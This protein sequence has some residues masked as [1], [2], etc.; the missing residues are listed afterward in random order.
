MTVSEGSSP[1]LYADLCRLPS[2]KRAERIRILSHIGLI[3]IH[4]GTAMAFPIAGDSP[5]AMVTELNHDRSNLI[6]H[7]KLTLGS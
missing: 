4:P 1:E 5:R 6:K 7:L 3:Q 2:R